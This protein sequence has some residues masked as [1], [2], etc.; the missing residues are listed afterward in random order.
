MAN[1]NELTIDTG[2]SALDMAEAIFGTGI[3]V[4]DATYSGHANASGIYSGADVTMPG[5]APAASGVILSTGNVRDI[6]NSDGSTD[7]NQSDHTGTTHGLPGEAGLSTQSGAATHDAAIL[8]ATFIPDGDFITMRFVF[9]SDEYSDVDNATAGD[10]FGIW[11]NG[12]YIPATITESGRIGTDTVNNTSNQYLYKENARDEFNTEMDGLTR[13]LSFK[14]P[15]NAGAPNTI[16]IAI[17]DG[18][19]TGQDSN[20]LIAGDSI[21]TG[22]LAF[23]DTV[24]LTGNQPVVL[25]LL[26]NDHDASGS[27][28]QITHILDMPITPNGGIALPDGGMIHMDPNGVLTIE[29]STAT[30]ASQAIT[31]TV[32]NANGDSDIGFLILESASPDGIVRGTTGDDVIDDVY[33]D[34]ADSDVID[35]GDGSGIG[36]TTGDGDDVL[37]GAG[38]D[39][40]RSG[41][42]DDIVSGESGDDTLAGGDGDD[43][44][45]GGPGNDNL[46]GEAGNDTL[47]GGSGDDQISGGD[48]DDLIYGDIAPTTGTT[49]WTSDGDGNLYRVDDATGTPDLVL[50]GSM[51]KTLGD[52]AVHPDGTLYGLSYDIQPHLVTIDPNSGALTEIGPVAPDAGGFNGLTFGADG[53]GYASGN[54]IYTFDVA[55]PLNAELFWQHPAGGGSNGDLAFA[56]G[57]LYL[58]WAHGFGQMRDVDLIELTLDVNG[59][60]A[61]HQSLGKLPLE[62]YGLT[63][64]ANGSLYA[65]GSGNVLQLDLSGGPTTGAIPGIALAGTAA[66]GTFY[67]AGSAHEAPNATLAS[68][69]D[70]IDGGDGNDTI[71]AG[72]GNDAIYGGADNDL[73]YGGDGDDVIHLGDHAGGGA[74]T[75]YG[76]AGDDR[77]VVSPGSAVL[78][79]HGDAGFDTLD[80]G[81]HINTE[82]RVDMTGDNAGVFAVGFDTQGAF[83]GI[84]RIETGAG[85]DFFFGWR[86]NV[87]LEISTGAGRDHIAATSGNDLVYGGADEDYVSGDAG[88]DTIYGGAGDDTLEGGAGNDE[89]YGDDGRDQIF[90][91]G[92]GHDSLYGGADADYFGVQHGSHIDGGETVTD[93]ED[94]DVL[95]LWNVSSVVFDAENRENGTAYLTNGQTVTFTNIETVI[96]DGIH[97]SGPPDGV[98]SGTM[99]GDLIDASYT[100]D[101]HGDMVDAGDAQLAG[102]AP[103]DDII[104]GLGGNDTILAGAGND[105]VFGGSGDDSVLGGVGNDTIHGGSGDD[106][107]H[108]EAGDDLIHGE[109]GDDS[110]TGGNGDDTLYGGA[111]A[112]TI[113][114]GDGNDLI[115]GGTAQTNVTTLW[116]SDGDSN[117]IR[118]DLVDGV[119]TQTIVGKMNIT[120]GDLALHSDGTLYAVDMSYPSNIFAINTLTGSE[121]LVGTLPAGSP[122]MSG[123]GSGSDGDLYVTGGSQIWRLDPGNPSE[124]VRWW[125]DPDGGFSSGDIVFQDDRAYLSWHNSHGQALVELRLDA[126]GDVLSSQTLGTLPN[127][128]FGL[129]FGPEGELYA[130]ADSVHV[131][132]VPAAPLNGGDDAIPTTLLPGTAVPN[133]GFYIGGHFS[134]ASIHG[135]ATLPAPDLDDALYGGAG[136]DTIHGDQGN[137]SLFGGADDD[138]LYGGAG[139]DRLDGGSGQDRLYGGAG[140]D[141]LYGGAG[142]DLLFGGDGHDTF[143]LD[144]G[145]D[146]AAGGLGRDTFIITPGSTTGLIDGGEGDLDPDD[147]FDTI[148]L[149]ALD[150]GSYRLEYDSANPENGTIHFL[151]SAGN[152]TSSLPFVNIERIIPCFTP[153]S[154]VTTLAGLVPVEQIGPGDLVLTRDDGFQPVRWVGRRDLG[155]GDMLANPGY[156]PVRIP[157]GALGQNLPAREMI[158]SPQ[159]RMLITDTGTDL[160]F[161]EQEVLVAALH[162]VGRRGVE[163]LAP[164]GISYIHLLFDRHEIIHVDGAWT[165]SYQPGAASLPGHADPQREE[166]LALFPE[167]AAGQPWPAARMTL[168]RYE[169]ELLALN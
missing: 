99:A 155:L 9:S 137:D 38:N 37:A 116:S 133:P 41:A 4:V 142:D 16:K 144:G 76:G 131:L 42:G 39:L 78:G 72:D 22:V 94:L 66:P 130:L 58:V 70:T 135:G 110:I 149:S 118:I 166:L 163:R 31:Y 91:S 19:V 146:T 54:A 79:V 5:V 20:L 138:A 150:P 46:S 50:V 159:H 65:L 15:V 63:T 28:L 127:N 26:A 151:D 105:H 153:G 169:V 68:G 168:K 148:D 121:S 122:G 24:V 33:V 140:N 21:Q 120:P 88:N 87:G 160:L 107:L 17:A 93:G 157:V 84:D 109:L 136:D 154:L 27:G 132:Q 143:H 85:N 95:Q 73:I 126:N 96:A 52:I 51:G 101:R 36:G 125:T 152:T 55:D 13:V 115:H 1:A 90:S 83:T 112:D 32:Q 108:G 156:A 111:G 100:G 164:R 7:T 40:V 60:V 48:G 86:S 123:L 114:G 165:E 14:A 44:L 25:D 59:E 129:A 134:G 113:E 147:D 81:T 53:T 71:H 45:F 106:S 57:K 145:A 75:A 92:N 98:V 3:L 43:Q 162:L 10:N 82:T 64:D 47:H 158:V 139:D 97:L 77:F 56:N 161:G 30:G 128:S 49:L 6:T 18:A 167:L 2:A 34:S 8:S 11:V 89:I 103:D 104:D 124:A 119:A 62:T 80:L 67:G 61:S 23:D 69:N 117:L 74:D 102:A 141:T 12:I 29:G 35:G